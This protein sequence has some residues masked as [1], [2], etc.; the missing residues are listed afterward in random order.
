MKKKLALILLAGTLVLSCTGCGVMTAFTEAFFA[1]LAN[2]NQDDE[3]E[4]DDKDKESKESEESKE[5]ESVEE[6]Q[7]MEETESSEEAKSTEAEESSEA[8]SSVVASSVA[9]NSVETNESADATSEALEVE[10]SEYTFGTFT[11]TGYES[12]YLN[13]RF[14]TPKRCKLSNVEELLTLSGVR[15][16][17]ASED[18]LFLIEIL[19]SQMQL[20]QI[21]AEHEDTYSSLTM[22]LEPTEAKPREAE[23]AL[24]DLV[25]QITSDTQ[26]NYEV[27]ETETVEIAGVEYLKTP[28]Y[29]KVD[30][31]VVVQELYGA[32][33]KDRFVHIDIYYAQ[34]FEND[35]DAFLDAFA[36]LNE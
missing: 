11:D 23:D 30:G 26:Y 7:S 2:S 8:A 1:E 35:R 6:S 18:G 32:Y 34:I 9:E 3:D 13:L 27:G 5:P 31:A 20:V 17:W 12:E 14:T 16:E 21:H 19:A 25:D 10:L 33:I 15:E 36:V 24:N 4:D 28:I 29:Y 22:V